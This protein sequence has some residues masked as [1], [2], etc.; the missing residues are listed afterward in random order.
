M[1]YP[2]AK[3]PRATP[4]VFKSQEK[5]AAPIVF[6]VPVVAV[7]SIGQVGPTPVPPLLGRIVV[8]FF[9]KLGK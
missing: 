2:A 9:M 3:T 8:L 4:I 5:G 1:R 7:D 6:V